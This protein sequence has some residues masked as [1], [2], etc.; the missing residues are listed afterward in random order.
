MRPALTFGLA[1]A[2]ALGG[3]HAGAAP[4]GNGVQ[5]LDAGHATALQDSVRAFAASVAQGVTAH[6]P[7]AWRAYFADQ[8]T[9][10]MASEGRLVFPNSDTATRAIERLTHILK[11]VE[12][13]WG[14]SL[15][16]DPLAPGLAILATSYHEVQVDAQGRRVEEDGFFTGIA[17]HQTGGW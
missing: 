12:L 11:H 17:E 4:N 14:D 1:A 2:M 10:F 13:R 5:V 16:V 3:C 9:F 7:A 8:P 6:G 15:R